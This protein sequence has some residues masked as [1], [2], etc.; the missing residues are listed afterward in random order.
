MCFEIWPVLHLYLLPRSIHNCKSMRMDR[1]RASGSKSSHEKRNCHLTTKGIPE[2]SS[3]TISLGPETNTHLCDSATTPTTHL[4]I[5]AIF[6]HSFIHSYYT[7]FDSEG[8]TNHP[9]VTLVHLGQILKT[10]LLE[11]YL[12]RAVLRAR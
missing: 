3:I 4:P 2:A 10:T 6:I 5:F 9:S 7:S 8:G 12:Q 11:S 1:L